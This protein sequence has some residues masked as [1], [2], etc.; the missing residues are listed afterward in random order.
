MV[1]PQIVSKSFLSR[2]NDLLFIAAVMAVLGTSSVLIGGIWDSASHALK[3]PD[4]FW[5]IQHVT[6]Y[7]GVSIV[8]LSASFGTILSLKN[9]K[10]IIGMVLL[11]AGSVMQLGGGY[12][13]YSFHEIYGIDGLVTSSHLTIESGLLLASIGGFLTL[14]KFGYTKTKKL[15]PFAIVNVIFSATWIGFNLSLLVGAI[16]LCIPVYDL[17]SSGCSIM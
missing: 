10:V 13:D 14:S 2:Q 16:M 15:V 12:V 1:I 8:A 5:T 3:I 11:L 17:F 4:S 6:V 9:R 7:T